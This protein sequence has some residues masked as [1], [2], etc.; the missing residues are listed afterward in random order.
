MQN[1]VLQNSVCQKNEKIYL[2]L[3]TP[4]YNQSCIS[5][6]RVQGSNLRG[7][8]WIFK[9]A[10]GA[11]LN[12]EF[13]CIFMLQFQNFS[14]FWPPSGGVEYGHVCV[15]SYESPKVHNFR[16]FSKKQQK[17]GIFLKKSQKFLLK[18]YQNIFQIF[19]LPKFSN[20][21]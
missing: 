3:F 11:P 14:Q 1:L 21:G 15:T 7:G 20:F 17:V 10:G 9:I 16:D 18:S 12:F 5:N 19:S 4:S 2:L 13:Y 6:I 8:G